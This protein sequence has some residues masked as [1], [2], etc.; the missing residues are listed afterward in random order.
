MSFDFDNYERECQKIRDE[1]EDLLMDFVT[2][3]RDK[4]LSDRTVEKHHENIAFYLNEFLLHDDATP[5]EEG[6]F[7]VSSFLGNWFIRK[8]MWA[9]AGNIRSN[10]ASLK[11]FYTFMLEEKGLI[12]KVMLDEMKKEIKKMMPEW[13]DTLRRYDDP[14]I[15]NPF[16]I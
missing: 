5:A 14:N 6:M 12:E 16:A 7:F 13:I 3:L 11:K 2:W 10:A 8:A 9:S 4:N 15:D 1:N